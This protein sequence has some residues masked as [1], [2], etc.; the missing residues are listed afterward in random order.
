MHG[1]C[2]AGDGFSEDPAIGGDDCN[3][4]IIAGALDAQD[5]L[6]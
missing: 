4:R 2:L 6:R 3:A 1:A 5:Q